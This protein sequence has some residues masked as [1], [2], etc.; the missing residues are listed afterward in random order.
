MELACQFIKD[1][2]LKPGEYLSKSLN[3]YFTEMG[4]RFFG[5]D[6][7]ISLYDLP[8]ILEPRSEFSRSFDHTALM[9]LPNPSRI[10]EMEA[11]EVDITSCIPTEGEKVQHYNIKTEDLEYFKG[12]HS[13]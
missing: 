8:V 1:Q 5:E 2:Y 12:N 9:H 6:L 10:P 3:E 4:N 11:Y 13:H 7:D